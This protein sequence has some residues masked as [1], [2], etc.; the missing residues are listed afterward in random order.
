MSALYGDL[1]SIG[2]S[3]ISK[4]SNSIANFVSFSALTNTP[5]NTGTFKAQQVLVSG[6]SPIVTATSCEIRVGLVSGYHV[7]SYLEIQASGTDFYFN[8]VIFHANFTFRD[9]GILKSIQGA[10]S[11]SPQH[12]HTFHL[13]KR[14]GDWLWALN[15]IGF[16]LVDSGIW[17]DSVD[18]DHTLTFD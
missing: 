16:E 7:N 17:Q 3:A 6:T 1:D 11:S 4:H 12:G 14:C 13:M 18:P 8:V 15:F 9:L 2:K 5:Y 10:E